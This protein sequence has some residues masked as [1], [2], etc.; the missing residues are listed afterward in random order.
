[1]PIGKGPR[2]AAATPSIL[3]G[4][5]A[6][7]GPAKGV[8]VAPAAELVVARLV[9]VAVPVV[10][11]AVLL[12]LVVVVAAAS[13]PSKRWKRIRQPNL[14]G[15]I[16]RRQAL[17]RDPR[18]PGSPRRERTHGVQITLPSQHHER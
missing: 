6:T 5:A 9:V 3:A 14:G 2:S 8:I 10:L 16:R 15:F 11:V 13:V 4:L 1:V 12:V 18:V 7:V 17:Q